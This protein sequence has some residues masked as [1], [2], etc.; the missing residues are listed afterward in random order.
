MTLEDVQKYFSPDTW[1]KMS[2]MGL[3]SVPATA[4]A[5]SV[6]KYFDPVAWEKLQRLGCLRGRPSAAS[7]ST[8]SLP[9][10]SAAE[11]PP[12]VAAAKSCFSP[13]SWEALTRLNVVPMPAPVSP[14][15]PRRCRADNEDEDDDFLEDGMDEDED[16]DEC[17]DAASLAGAVRLDG[18]AVADRIREYFSQDQWRKLQERGVLENALRRLGKETSV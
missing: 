15:R 8:T 14:R 17:C 3:H 13:R 7:S 10:S 1:R 12:S 4:S 18:L 11:E 6:Q 5:S 16:A 9:S 2:G